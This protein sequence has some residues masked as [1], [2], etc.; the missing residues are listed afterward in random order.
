VPACNANYDADDNLITN[1]LVALTFYLQQTAGYSSST[2]PFSSL[3][4]EKSASWTA[5]S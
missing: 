4:P 2:G 5:P 1:Q 3:A